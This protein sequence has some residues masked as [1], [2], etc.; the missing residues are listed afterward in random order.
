MKHTIC[1]GLQAKLQRRSPQLLQVVMAVMMLLL[2]F[3][4][5]ESYPALW[6]EET[7]HQFGPEWVCKLKF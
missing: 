3:R 7:M 4:R 2:L 6:Q 1:Q 5:P